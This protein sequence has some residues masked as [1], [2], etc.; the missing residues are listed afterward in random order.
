MSETVVVREAGKRA[1]LGF[2]VDA[3]THGLDICSI[4]LFAINEF[5]GSFIPIGSSRDR[6][7]RIS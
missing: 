7:K 4:R 6:R 1:N 2:E 5:Q 3:Q